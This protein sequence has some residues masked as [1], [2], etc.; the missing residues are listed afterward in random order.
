MTRR[1]HSA[2]TIENLLS[3]F[4]SKW[5]EYSLAAT[6]Q[7]SHISLYHFVFL[8]RPQINI[9][10]RIKWII[11]C[12]STS[13]R[14]HSIRFYFSFENLI[15]FGFDFKCALWARALRKSVKAF[16]KYI[17]KREKGRCSKMWIKTNNGFCIQSHFL[18]SFKEISLNC[19]LG[20][21]FMHL[22]LDV[23]PFKSCFT[24]RMKN[25][26]SDCVEH[27]LLWQKNKNTIHDENRLSLAEFNKVQSC[28]CN[29]LEMRKSRA[30]LVFLLKQ[31]SHLKHFC[32]PVFGTHSCCLLFPWL[33]N[34]LLLKHWLKLFKINTEK[35]C[36]HS[37]CTSIYKN[38]TF[39]ELISI[40][41]QSDRKQ[42]LKQKTVQNSC[43]K[44]KILNS[45]KVHSN[46]KMSLTSSQ[47]CLKNIKTISQHAIFLFSLLSNRCK[48]FRIHLI[49][50][51]NSMDN[52][53]CQKETADFFFIRFHCAFLLIANVV[54]HRFCFKCIPST[55]KITLEQFL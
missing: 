29:S 24:F 1:V 5:N 34:N 49:R 11:R 40:N 2:R 14:F 7:Y 48:I 25:K 44:A 4:Y 15:I 35:M 39:T 23:E 6:R 16:C 13:V 53:V 31:D 22:D 41:E 45:K 36:Q 26:T 46:Q 28:N 9:Q 18:S 17:F 50:C 33:F 20:H 38:L 3:M 42:H 43:V 54:L 47:N 32:M 30:S 37:V 10:K 55:A 51:E 52:S 12:Q 21:R 19:Y 8:Y 27:I